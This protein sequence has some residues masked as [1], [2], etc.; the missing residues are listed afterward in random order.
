MRLRLIY[1]PAV[2]MHSSLGSK[3]CVILPKILH[4]VYCVIRT[5]THSAVSSL[6]DSTSVF[7]V[8]TSSSIFPYTDSIRKFSRWRRLLLLLLE[9][10][11][12]RLGTWNSPIL[13]WDSLL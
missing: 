12:C 6:A 9:S 7:R 2:Q 13:G 5:T 1:R 11:I 8:L 10:E 4:Q 3:N